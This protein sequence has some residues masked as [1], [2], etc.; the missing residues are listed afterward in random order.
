MSDQTAQR[1]QR[2]YRKRKRAAQELRTREQITEATV[3]LHESVGPAHT[4]VKAIAERAGVQR[5]TVYRHFP[6]QQALFDACTGLYLRRHPMPDPHEWAGLAGPDERLRRALAD[7]YAWYG[8]TEQMLSNSFR[9]VEHVP[10]AT[11][12][13]FLGYFDSARA[14]LMAGRPERGR[15]R[16]RVSGAI[17]H[18]IGFATWRSLT[19]EQGLDDEDAVALMAAMTDAAGR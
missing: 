12:Q 6:D 8:D 16:T 1:S 2:A 10:V 3:A 4:T 17:G 9:D 19:R 14:A 11:M 13:S 5:A 18:A 7:L 15:A